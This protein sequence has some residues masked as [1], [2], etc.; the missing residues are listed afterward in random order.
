MLKNWIENPLK[1]K[2]QKTLIHLKNK[3]TVKQEEVYD[4]REN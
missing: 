4:E 1:N 2:I 3:I